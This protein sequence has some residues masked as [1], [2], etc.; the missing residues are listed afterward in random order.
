[1]KYIIAF[2]IALLSMVYN[3]Y[4]NASEGSICVQ[5]TTEDTICYDGYKVYN[6]GYAYNWFKCVE[7]SLDWLYSDRKV[8]CVL[9]VDNIEMDYKYIEKANQHIARYGYSE[10][11]ELIEIKKPN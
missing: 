8:V 3:N 6:Y 9:I 5:T 10:F 4:T 7:D 11:L 1:M 2:I